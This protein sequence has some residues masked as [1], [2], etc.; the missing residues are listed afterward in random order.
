MKPHSRREVLRSWA[1]DLQLQRDVIVREG[2]RDRREVALRRATEALVGLADDLGNDAILGI[3]EKG[4]KAT[5]EEI[6][7]ARKLLALLRDAVGDI[8]ELIET[9]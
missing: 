3:T 5:T 2:K 1:H 9:E 6:V 7:A 4:A 8:E